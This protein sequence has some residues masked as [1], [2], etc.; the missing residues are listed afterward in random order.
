M[1]SAE[2]VRLSKRKENRKAIDKAFENSSKAYLIH[3]SC[4][5]FY[6]NDSGNS[7]RVTSIAVRSLNSAQ[8]R[9]WSIHKSA[10]L[11]ECLDTI[12]KN[13]DKL[14]L[15]ML[16]DYFQFLSNNSDFTYIHW[17]MR[18]E[19][20]GFQAIEHRFKVL[21]GTPYILQDDKK[22]DLARV[23]VALYGRSYCSHE[24][25]SGKKGRLMVLTEMN[26]IASLDALSGQDEANAFVSGEYLKL[27][28]STLRKVD[29]FANIIDRIHSNTLKTNAKFFDKYGFNPVAIIEIIKAHP[30]YSFIGLVSTG[31]LFYTRVFGLFN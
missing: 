27:H 5:S 26:G 7:R 31:I 25:P 10:E 18:D 17:N 21:G 3:Y 16:T 12:N 2:L 24:S 28:R 23:L 9:S 22:L 14:E 30:A 29:I 13:L 1:A 8:T 19:A 15:H 6:D 11:C 4:E 20:Y